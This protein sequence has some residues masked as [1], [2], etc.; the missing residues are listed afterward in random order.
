MRLQ[1][2]SELECLPGATAPR[3]AWRPSCQ[4]AAWL[5]TGAVMATDRDPPI[6]PRA[7]VLRDW[8]RQMAR[9]C[10]GREKRRIVSA[11]ICLG[12]ALMDLNPAWSR[13]AVAEW[14]EYLERK[15]PADH[16]KAGESPELAW[17]EA[18]RLLATWRDQAAE[19]APDE[20]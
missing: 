8:T 11:S 19:P 17:T 6:G 5:E 16:P 14:A 10:E 7:R 15:W 3:Q 1:L 4:G 13:A 12:M 20:E 2:L 18:A 9:A